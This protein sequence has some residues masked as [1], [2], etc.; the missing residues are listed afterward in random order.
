MEYWIVKNNI[1]PT[2]TLTEAKE[3]TPNCDLAIQINGKIK[4]YRP[5]IVDK[6]YKKHYF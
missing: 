1:K 5:D 6:D 2:W 3:S 4:R